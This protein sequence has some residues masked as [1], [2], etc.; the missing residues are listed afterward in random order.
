M[1]AK[2]PIANWL[3]INS[4]PSGLCNAANAAATLLFVGFDETG[5]GVCLESVTYLT[6]NESW[7]Q[8]VVQVGKYLYYFLFGW[9][10][11]KKDVYG[12]LITS[13][14]QVVYTFQFQT[15]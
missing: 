3:G 7:N 11:A 2:F 14:P 10:N 1:P 12:E 5:D 6:I 13:C 8:F 15:E 9:W 4:G